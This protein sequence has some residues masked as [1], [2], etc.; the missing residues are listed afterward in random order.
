MVSKPAEPNRNQYQSRQSRRILNLSICDIFSTANK[1]F[2]VSSA[3]AIVTI[4]YQI[5]LDSKKGNNA[6]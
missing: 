6:K 4:L 1:N 2:C 3:I 5:S